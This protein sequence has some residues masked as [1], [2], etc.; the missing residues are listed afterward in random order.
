MK[1]TVLYGTE[2]G[3]SRG[4]AQKV[5]KKG[6]KNGVEVDVI[7]LAEYT[8][9]QLA[10][11]DNPFVL[12]ISTWDDGEPPADCRDFCESLA[13]TDVDLSGKQYTVL[14]L[15]DTEYPL[16]CECGKKVD[17]RLTELGA[18]AILPRTDLG[19]EFMVTYIGWSKN[20]WKTLAGV[21]GIK[22]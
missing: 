16:F 6:E 15:G 10:Q 17:A 19:A 12:I 14:A 21:Y 5:A 1:L 2:T 8:V 9:D 11:L 7:D 20:L 22:K 4:L 3:N 18:T 13:S